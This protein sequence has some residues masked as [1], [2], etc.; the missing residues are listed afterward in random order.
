MGNLLYWA[1]IF[2]IIALVAAF[3]GFGGVAGV[4]TEGARMLF[5]VAIILVILSF[6]GSLIRRG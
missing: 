4:A 6:V 3:F 1:V 5:W 2:L